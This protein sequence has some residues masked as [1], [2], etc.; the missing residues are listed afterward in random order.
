MARA[1][2]ESRHHPG[3]AL[4]EPKRSRAWRRSPP[5]GQ[6]QSPRAIRRRPLWPVLTERYAAAAMHDTILND[7]PEQQW[8]PPE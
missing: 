7:R 6:G 5:A 3:I 8:T 4:I 1:G 2:A